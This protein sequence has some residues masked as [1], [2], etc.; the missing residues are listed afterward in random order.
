MGKAIRD[1]RQQVILATKVA[2]KVG[3]GP[4]EAGLSRQHIC[5]PTITSV[6][7]GASSLKQLEENLGAVEINLTPEELSACDGGWN[8]GR[9][10]SSMAD[11]AFPPSNHIYRPREG[12]TLQRTSRFW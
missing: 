6:I 2:S 5:N 1:K 9:S 8:S 11:E 12:L 3:S 7:M 10:D 4:N